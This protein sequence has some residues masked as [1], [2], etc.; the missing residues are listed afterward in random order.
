MFK[1]LRAKWKVNPIQLFLILITFAAGGSLCGMVGRKL[2]AYIEVENNFINLIL[3]LLI[4][5]LIW[6]V[7]VLLISIPMGQFTFFKNYINRIIGRMTYQNKH[8]I[9]IFASGTGTNAKK[10][11]EHFANHPQIQVTLIVSNKA[12]AGVLT[13]AKENKIDTLIIEKDRFFKGDAYL[14]ELQSSQINF[15][16]LAGFLW[17]VP[18]ALIH[19]YPNQ[20]IN[21]HPALLPKYGGKGM[22]GHFVHEA[23]IDAK[24]KESGITI[25][26]VDEKYDHGSIIFQATCAVEENDTANELAN[27]IHALEHQHFAGIIE[28]CILNKNG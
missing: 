8:H 9:A 1:Q 18:S 14:N 10:I 23:V 12:E 20:I 6:P 13:I 2:L 16:V 5:I 19:A 7:C 15:I 25:H 4:I 26:Y 3:Y 27:R 21:I 24:E 22:Y 28:Q 17:K 11:I